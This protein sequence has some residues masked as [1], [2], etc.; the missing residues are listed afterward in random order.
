MCRCHS[1]RSALFSDRHDVA[2]VAVAWALAWRGVTGAIVGARRPKQIDG[3]HPGAELDLTP[4]RV[5]A[6]NMAAPDVLAAITADGRRP[7]AAEREA[8]ARWHGWGA[9]PQLFDRPEFAAEREQLRERLGSAGFNAAARTTLNALYTDARIVRGRLGCGRGAR[10]DGGLALEPG[11]EDGPAKIS[12]WEAGR[13][14]SPC[15]SP[16]TSSTTPTR[17]SAE[18]TSD[19]AC[20]GWTCG[21]RETASTSTRNSPPPSAA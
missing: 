12:P 8:L 2:A 20:T 9:A 3:W 6:D 10:R 19:T 15:W 7:A 11:W 13:S 1:G 14:R 16:T 5:V 18:W 4:R 21:S 17:C